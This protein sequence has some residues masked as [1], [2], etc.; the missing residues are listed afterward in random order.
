MYS[1]PPIVLLVACTFSPSIHSATD[2]HGCQSSVCQYQTRI[3]SKGRPRIQSKLQYEFLNKIL[4]TDDY[5]EGFALF[6]YSGW[7]DRGQVMIFR[8][9]S[10]A[11][12]SYYRPNTRNNP[13]QKTIVLAELNNFVG[14]LIDDDLHDFLPKVYDGIEYEYVHARKTAK[15]QV[16]VVTRVYMKMPSL[17]KSKPNRYLQIVDLFVTLVDKLFPDG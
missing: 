16:E 13:Q 1:F 12:V 8:K 3:E 6:S 7:S 2:L 9:K 10:D 5:Q 14:N 11:D 17:S 4:Q 15:M